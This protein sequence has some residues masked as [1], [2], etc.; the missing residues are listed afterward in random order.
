MAVNN[1]VLAQAVYLNAG[2][3]FQ[4]RI[5]DPT[6]G[7]ISATMR[8]LFAPM[9]RKFLNEFVDILINK[10]AFTVV[11]GKRWENPLAVFEKKRID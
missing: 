4:Q 10:V 3:D 2:N 11:R 8:D 5:T 9:N 6:V 1:S 7:G